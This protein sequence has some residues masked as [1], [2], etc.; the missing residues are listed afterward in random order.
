ME[1][2]QLDIVTGASGFS[3]RYI[4]RRLLAMG[5]R[6][7]TITGNPDRPNEFGDRVVAEPF[8]FDNPAALT[9]S[10]RGADVLFNSYWIRFA[11]GDVNF[12]KAVQNSKTLIKAAADAGVRKFVHISIANPS[13]DSPLPYYHGKAVVE[14]AIRDSGMSYAILRPT[15]I[16]GDHG[17]LINN[18]AW[19]LRHLPVFVVAGDGQYGIRPIFVED[20]AE[21]AVNLS[22]SE[23][24][25]V[26]DAVGPESYTFTGLVEMLR[27]TIGTHTMI[28][29]MPPALP[30]LAAR[31]LG[32]LLGDV[33]L[34]SDEVIGLTSGLLASDQPSTGDTHLSAWVRENKDWL[35]KT[36]MSELKA[37]YRKHVA[38]SC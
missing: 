18:I 37:H 22:Q 25:C 33:V 3:G 27:Q 15:V 5:R 38:G 9:E 34:T 11:H 14:E 1:N 21:L 28:M 7:K 13:I 17:I 19:F 30:L 36:Y 10:L 31:G 24:N 35:G 20:L 32:M 6:V 29:K 8:N 4:T 16:F 12:D 2:S 26:I 23:E